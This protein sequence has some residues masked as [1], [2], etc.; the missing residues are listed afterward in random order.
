M[1]DE[2]NRDK[3]RRKAMQANQ[4]EKSAREL[5]VALNTF[6]PTKADASQ[7]VTEYQKPGAL[8]ARLAYALGQ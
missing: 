2:Q 8:P 3:Q 1:Y 6:F 5:A 7:L 4:A